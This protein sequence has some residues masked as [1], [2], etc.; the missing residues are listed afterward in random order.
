MTA[1]VADAY[2]PPLPFLP[3]RVS[4]THVG[5][6]GGNRKRNDPVQQ[7]LDESVVYRDRIPPKGDHVIDRR[8]YPDPVLEPEIHAAEYHKYKYIDDRSAKDQKRK[9]DQIG[10]V[11]GNP[12]LDGTV[13]NSGH[14]NDD[15][16]Q[17]FQA[18]IFKQHLKQRVQWAQ[19]HPV[20]LSFHDIGVAELIEV[21]A[22]K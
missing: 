20:K 3:D 15:F 7:E 5:V 4:E 22:D 2:R 17:G 12:E 6:K 13:T 16:L 10:Q 8:R 18:E 1:V 14:P 19:E 21:Q 9:L 11:P